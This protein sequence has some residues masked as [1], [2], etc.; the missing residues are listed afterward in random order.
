MNFTYDLTTDV[1]KARF[2]LG[3]VVQGAGVKPDGSNFSDEELQ[4][5]IDREGSAL[6]AVQAACGTLARLWSMVSDIAV[7]PRRENLSQIA[8]S[9]SQRADEMATDAG[10]GTFGFSMPTARDDG[11][12]QNTGDDYA[13]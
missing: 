2:E 10:G 11:F 4:M 9:W 7:G 8:K 13:N 6:R 5:L 1:G 3:D 12:S